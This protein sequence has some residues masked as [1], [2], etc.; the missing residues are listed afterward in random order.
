MKAKGY[1]RIINL[2]SLAARTGG[3]VA[4]VH[5]VVTKAGVLGLTKVLAKEAAPLGINVNAINPGRIDTPM[6]H[7]VPDEVN[8]VYVDRIPAG[9]LGLP[10]DVAKVV[11]FLASDLSGY[12]TGTSIEVNGGLFMG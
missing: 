9:R 3:Y 11:L 2:A 5:Y 6:I 4:P 12:I 1:G 8:Q 10:E 7:D